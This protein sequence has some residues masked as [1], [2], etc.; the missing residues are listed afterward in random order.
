MQKVYSA[1]RKGNI[2]VGNAWTAAANLSIAGYNQ[3]RQIAAGVH[4]MQ[5]SFWNLLN[6]DVQRHAFKNPMHAMD[7]G[8]SI[9]ICTGVVKKLQVL[10]ESILRPGNYFNKKLTAR[11]YNLCHK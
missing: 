11:L 5:N 8:I 2:L 3:A 9:S 1:A 10:A 7:Y 4:L 6:F